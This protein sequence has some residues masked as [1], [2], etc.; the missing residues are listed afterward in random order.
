M[1]TLNLV[2]LKK[3]FARFQEAVI[4][5]VIVSILNNTFHSEEIHEYTKYLQMLPSF[6]DELLLDILYFSSLYTFMIYY[7]F[8]VSLK[9]LGIFYLFLQRALYI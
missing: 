6:V 7:V 2:S 8:L 4:A 1:Y 3:D 9:L 5:A